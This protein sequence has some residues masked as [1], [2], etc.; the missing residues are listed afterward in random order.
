MEN[1]DFWWKIQRSGVI[2]TLLLQ[3]GDQNLLL[4][5]FYMDLFGVNGSVEEDG[6]SSGLWLSTP[7]SR[8]T[9][10]YVED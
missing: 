7:S 3:Y 2:S 8:P 4:W 9:R 5:K 10:N 1:E 6:G